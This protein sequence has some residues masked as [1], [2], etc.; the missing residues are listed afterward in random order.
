M[1]K[2]SDYFGNELLIF[3]KSIW[4]REF[5]LRSGDEV[6]AQMIYPKIFQ[7]LGGAYHSERKL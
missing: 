1:R 5:E 2:L 4:K 3:Q 7:P 6:I